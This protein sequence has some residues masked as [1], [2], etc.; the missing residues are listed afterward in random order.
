MTKNTTS[1]DETLVIKT[2]H[3]IILH[4][5]IHCSPEAYAKHLLMASVTVMNSHLFWSISTG[6][7]SRIW[8]YAEAGYGKEIASRNFSSFICAA[9]LNVHT[10]IDMGYP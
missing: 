4:V 9:V 6:Y 2:S 5:T 1:V 3:L 10:A 8:F 7:G